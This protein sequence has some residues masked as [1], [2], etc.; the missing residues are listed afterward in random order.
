MRTYTAAFK[1]SR[2]FQLLDENKKI[3]GE[4][5]Y[6]KWY[7]AQA[8]VTTEDQ[9]YKISVNGFWK[10]SILVQDEDHTLLKFTLSWS[11]GIIM[12]CFSDAQEQFKI[13]NKIGSE[14]YEMKDHTDQIVLTIKR[15]LQWNKM[16]GCYEVTGVQESIPIL[17]I[18]S[19][20][21][22]IHFIQSQS[23]GTFIM[24]I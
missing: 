24:T 20:L 5:S 19:I 16:S 3:L 11:G 4:I 7:S 18:L 13:Y 21:Y 10:T 23:D 17:N 8:V 1:D 14:I 2:N 6:P 12:T 15:N 9:A 22:V